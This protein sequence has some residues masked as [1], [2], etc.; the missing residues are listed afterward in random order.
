VLFTIRQVKLHKK[1]NIFPGAKRLRC[2]C[3]R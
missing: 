3:V 2:C 1:H